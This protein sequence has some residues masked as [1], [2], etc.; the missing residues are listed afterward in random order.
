MKYLKLFESESERYQSYPYLDYIGE[1][2]EYRNKGG[3]VIPGKS[4]NNPL[5][6]SN[7]EIQTITS[8]CSNYDVRVNNDNNHVDIYTQWGNVN[9]PLHVTY[10]RKHDTKQILHLCQI[11]QLPDEWFYISFTQM[12]DNRFYKCDQFSGLM[13]CLKDN[14]F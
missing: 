12:I 13:D 11:Q 2:K 8:L 9:I 6:F 7:L 10:K 5:P 1:I 4:R 3:E 14:L